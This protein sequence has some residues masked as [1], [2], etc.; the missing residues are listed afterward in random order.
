MLNQ[1][2]APFKTTQK[3]NVTKKGIIKTKNANKWTIS[4]NKS[5]NEQVENQ[6]GI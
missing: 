4:K 3:E 6:T 1:K 2:Y 5:I